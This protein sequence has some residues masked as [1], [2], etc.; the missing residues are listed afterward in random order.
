VA[1]CEAWRG[2]V[3][4]AWRGVARRGVA[5]TIPRFAVFEGMVGLWV[6]KESR[7][8]SNDIHKKMVRCTLRRLLE[9]WWKSKKIMEGSLGILWEIKWNSKENVRGDFEKKETT[10]ME[11]K[12]KL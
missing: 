5:S 3:L 6:P 8:K 7:T 10:L 9:I 12:G 11:F 1:W 2:V 4:G